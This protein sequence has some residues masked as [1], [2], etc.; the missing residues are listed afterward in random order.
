MAGATGPITVRNGSRLAPAPTP[1]SRNS[2][3]LNQA[4][5]TSRPTACITG[6]AAESDWRVSPSMLGEK[7][8]SPV[9]FE[10][11]LTQADGPVGIV[12]I[13]RPQ[14]RNALNH[15]T[16]AEIV[17][18]LEAFD[19]DPAI[20]CLI[21]TGNDRAFAAGAAVT[22]MAGAVKAGFGLAGRCAPGKPSSSETRLARSPPSGSAWSIASSP[23]TGTSR[24]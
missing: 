20:R 9:S 6:R 10:F 21:L 12:T 22:E 18:A 1:A 17:Q 2:T 15:K 3:R 24:R 11:I 8:G 5:T 19:R 14:L 4:A 23:S 7:E 13:N 16:I